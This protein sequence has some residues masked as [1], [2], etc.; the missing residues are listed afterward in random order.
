MFDGKYSISLELS[1]K[2]RDCS[3]ANR[4]TQAFELAWCYTD[5][6][7]LLSPS[8]IPRWI[9]ILGFFFLCLR[10]MFA[11]TVPSEVAAVRTHFHDFMLDVHK[12]LHKSKARQDPLDQV[13]KVS[14]SI[15]GVGSES[16][17]SLYITSTCKRAVL[18]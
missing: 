6:P 5:A 8:N 14:E 10:D 12:R 18:G 4:R 15:C 11:A 3:C 16:T 2:N 7:P 17:L 13:S 9:L 1:H